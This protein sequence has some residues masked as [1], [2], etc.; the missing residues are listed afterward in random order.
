MGCDVTI[1]RRSCGVLISIHA[2]RVG[3][4]RSSRA[5]PWVNGIFQSTHPVWGATS[6]RASRSDD[7]PIFQSTHPVWGATCNRKFYGGGLRFQSTHPVWGA[8]FKSISHPSAKTR[9]QSTHPVW[10]ATILPTSNTSRTAISIHAPRVGCD[11]AELKK[12]QDAEISIHA[13]R[14]GCD[15]RRRSNKKCTTTFQSTH[16]VWGAT[17]NDYV[18][19]ESE[20][21]ISIH[22][23]RV[24]CDGLAAQFGAFVKDFNP[25]TPCGVRP[26]QEQAPRGGR[27]FNPRT[28]CGV[29]RFTLSTGDCIIRDFNPR[30][31]CGVRHWKPGQLT[32]AFTIS[33]HAPRVGCDRTCSLTDV[34]DTRFQSTHPVWGATMRSATE[35]PGHSENFNP[36]TPCGVRRGRVC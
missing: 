10:G 3:C 12:Y 7:V 35:A 27:Y 31:P 30:T 26:G 36:R 16:P 1:Q 9:F 32:P 15:R 24:G 22:A 13:P 34:P 18:R 8:T 29:R 23:P 28:P 17:P 2:P 25:R 11:Q 5:P 33:I 20:S 14:V 6:R 19:L 4:D 21:A